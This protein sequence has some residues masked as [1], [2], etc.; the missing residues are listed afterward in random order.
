MRIE[1][2]HRDWTRRDDHAEQFNAR[3]SRMPVCEVKDTLVHLKDDEGKILSTATYSYTVRLAFPMEKETFEILTLNSFR[4]EVNGT[5]AL[6]LVDHQLAREVYLNG[7]RVSNNGPV[8]LA[9][10]AVLE[11]LAARAPRVAVPT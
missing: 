8:A 5:G 3:Y 2:E 7:T 10:C 6:E 1:L 11:R 4:L 9:E